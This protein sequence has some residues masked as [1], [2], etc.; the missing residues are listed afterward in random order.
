MM[1]RGSHSGPRHAGPGSGGRLFRSYKRL[2]YMGSGST[3]ALLLLV[4]GLVGTRSR[5]GHGL[6]P[7]ELCSDFMP[8][9]IAR[10]KTLFPP[11]RVGAGSPPEHGHHGGRLRVAVRQR[12]R[13]GALPRPERRLSIGCPP[14]DFLLPSGVCDPRLDLLP[15]QP[16]TH[17]LTGDC[18]STYR[19]DP[20]PS[21]AAMSW[22]SCFLCDA[23]SYFRSAVSRSLVI[24]PP[25][26]GV[27]SLDLGRWHPLAASF[28]AN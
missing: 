21:R 16:G 4:V 5:Y 26:L 13:D 27:S 1:R 8:T 17:P 7:L 12:L 2:V 10:G 11:P 18:L 6:Q 28:F 15:K 3:D 24:S 14:G 22:L 9:V 23:R 19:E 20:A 25:S